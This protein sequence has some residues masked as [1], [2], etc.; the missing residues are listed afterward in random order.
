M[1]GIVGQSRSDGG[2]VDEAL[3]QRMCQAL[4]HRGPDSRGIHR[5]GGTGLGIQ[6]LRVIDVEGGDQPVYNEDRSVAVV[7]NGEIYN[8]RELRRG[9]LERGHRLTTE[10]DAET[11]AHLYE[12][13]GVE[14]VSELEGMFA[15]ALWDQS[16]RR[17]LIGR[18]RLGKK[19]L[20]YSL[21]GDRIS[22]ASELA[23]LLQDRTIDRA[24]DPTALDGY[25]AYKYVPPPATAFAAVKV[26]PPAHTLVYEDGAVRIE[27]YWELRRDHVEERSA[28]ELTARLREQLR[29]A[30]G[31]RLVADVPLGAFLSGGI[32][33]AAVVAAMAEQSSRVK[34]FSIGF[35]GAEDSEL[36]LARVTAD[37]FGTEHHEAVV[38]ADALAAIP[39]IVRHYGQPFADTS[40]VPTYYVSKVAREQVTVALNGDGGDESF[41]G[42]DHY[43]GALRSDRAARLPGPVRRLLAVAGTRAPERADPWHPFSRARRLGERILLDGAGRYANA[44]S[45]FATGERSALYEPGFARQFDAEAS[46]EFIAAPWERA[47]GL[48]EINRMLAVDVA[49][50]LPGDLLPKMD[51]ASMACSLETRSPFLDREL[52]EFAATMPGSQKLR[53]G[54][55]KLALRTALRGWVPDLIL[56]SPKRGFG[57]PGVATWL[58]TDLRE[59]LQDAVGGRPRATRLFRAGT[60]RAPGRP[61]PG[62]Q[63][64]SWPENLVTD[65]A[66]ALAPRVRRPPAGAVSLSCG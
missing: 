24:V 14:C 48:D 43:L 61:A 59:L 8:Y 16:C 1:C 27:R 18:D 57:L 42:Y 50:Y 9:L 66:R 40:A 5:E 53:D 62:R 35:E 37:H 49:T 7:L 65:D 39:T 15:F 4:E 60:G 12:E 44:V 58:R 20:F 32:D 28:E 46:L 33:S 2:G 36:P 19:P 45:V 22:F 6:R 56:D 11:I 54:E 3:L 31:R 29:D 34:T 51:I 13:K 23:A 21:D 41:A 47:T 52:M 30:V 38:K 55:K 17:L 10:G 63:P 64:R 26:L 25:L